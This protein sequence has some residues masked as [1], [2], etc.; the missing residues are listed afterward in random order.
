LLKQRYEHDLVSEDA[1]FKPRALIIDGPSLL[2]ITESANN[3][4]EQQKIM[5]N[6]VSNKKMTGEKEKSNKEDEVR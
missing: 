4:S 3:N 5:P 6:E 2:L 1:S